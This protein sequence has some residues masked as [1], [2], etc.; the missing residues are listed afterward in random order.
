MVRTHV[1]KHLPGAGKSKRR[2]SKGDVRREATA[3]GAMEKSGVSRSLR[4][5][6]SEETTQSNTSSPLESDVPLEP[7]RE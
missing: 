7:Q 6:G 5:R 1:L 4:G 2:G 3:R